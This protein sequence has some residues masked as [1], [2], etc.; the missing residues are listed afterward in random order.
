MSE[1]RNVVLLTVDSLR[2]DYCGF[3]GS[4]RGLTPTLDAYAE[5]G[6]VFT[7]AISSGPS[8]L[9][10][11]PGIFTGDDIVEDDG[12][13]QDRF[14]HHMRARTTIPELFSEMGYETAGFTANPWT[15]RQ[16][17]FDVGF[18]HFEDFLEEA[19][20]D[21]G[22]GPTDAGADGTGVEDGDGSVLA[23][24]VNLV[25]R[26]VGESKMFQA[27]GSFYDD[28]IEWTE[29]AEEPYF[30]WLF[31]VDVH[32]P[33]LPVEGVRS[34]PTAATYAANLWLYLT[35]RE[36]GLLEPAF[37]SSLIRAYED[38]IRYTDEYF[39]EFMDDLAEDDPAVV[40][41]ADHG[42]AFGEKGIYGHGPT[43]STEQIH[44]PLFV[45]NG[46]TGEVD[47]PVSLRRIPD[48]LT[49][50]ATDDVDVDELTEGYV[51]AWNRNPKFAL[52]GEDWKYVSGDERT[53]YDLDADREMPTEE[54]E[55]ASLAED[56]VQHWQSRERER[57]R[58]TEATRDVAAANQL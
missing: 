36:P 10:A 58:I 34:Q 26:W 25:R 22:S 21:E 43:L 15:S 46:P 13:M 35:G 40:F 49:M 50:L 3:M 57:Q 32:M 7:N 27:W 24:P 55:L 37:R 54:S 45:A 28:V 12:E 19:T 31:L 5:D 51:G 4:D 20:D 48:L 39:G 29:Q 16:Y 2:A 9:D 30:L 1:R 41:H 11:L 42:E 52:R 6:L 38:T 33:Y 53:L 8:T 47:E 18:D 56:L 14:S 23:T 44:V 17:G